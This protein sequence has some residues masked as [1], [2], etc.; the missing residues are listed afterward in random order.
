MYELNPLEWYNAPFAG[1]LF[2][3]LV[4]FV[5][6]AVGVLD[7]GGIDMDGDDADFDADADGDDGDADDSHSGSLKDLI[8]WVFG[9]KSCPI[10]YAISI[11]LLVFGTVGYFLNTVILRLSY[12]EP[13]FVLGVA[14]NGFIG[15]VVSI[16]L[17]RTI[18]PIAARLLPDETPG[19]IQEDLVGREATVSTLLDPKTGG[20]VLVDLGHTV[21]KK[22]AYLE[23]DDLGDEPLRRGTKLLVIEVRES[24]LICTPIRTSLSQM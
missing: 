6:L 19:L 13:L 2:L 14:L 23:G 1:M 11:W 5:S 3:G 17:V 22:M 21:I 7:A 4:Y 8:V 9:I 12:F 16:F 24:K 18:A 20:M 15:F 10:T